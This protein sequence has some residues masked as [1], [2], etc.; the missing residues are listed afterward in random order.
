M[1]S[2]V[3]GFSVA[4]AADDEAGEAIE[5]GMIPNTP[6]PAGVA[7][8]SVNDDLAF[9]SIDHMPFLPREVM[10]VLQIQQYLCTQVLA[11][12]LWIRAWLAAA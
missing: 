10:M 6:W 1:R 11:K 2:R 9:N 7:P 12:W 8:L 4:F 5:P 3:Q